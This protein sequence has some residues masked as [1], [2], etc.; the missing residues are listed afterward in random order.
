MIF[1]C[2][3]CSQNCFFCSRHSEL[4]NSKWT[5]G[6]LDPLRYVVFRTRNSRN[7]H[8]SSYQHW[9]YEK[10]SLYRIKDPTGS[11]DYA[12]LRNSQKLCVGESDLSPWHLSQFQGFCT[13]FSGRWKKHFWILKLLSWISDGN[14][15]W[16]QT[17][18]FS[19]I[20][21]CIREMVIT[22][23]SS[24]WPIISRHALCNICPGIKCN[25]LVSFRCNI[26]SESQ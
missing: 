9:F 13:I 7:R 12:A 17:D 2:D 24:N 8:R 20:F 23:A 6:H 22:V 5:L 10:N 26:K 11:S 16:H 4:Q 1:A 15:I 21:Q 14:V 3:Q 25:F 18:W 19:C